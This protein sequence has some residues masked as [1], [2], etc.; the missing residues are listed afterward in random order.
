M[1]LSK[2][3]AWM[4][5]LPMMVV[6]LLVLFCP[7]CPAQSVD[8]ASVPI[9]LE[10]KIKV[11]GEAVIKTIPDIAHV[12]LGVETIGEN[13]EEVR[14]ASAEKMTA[15]IAAIK[16]SGISEAD[17]KTT[18]L[19]AYPYYSYANGMELAGYRSHNTLSVRVTDINKVSGL[20]DAAIA[21][22]TSSVM[23]VGWGLENKQTATNEAIQKAITN[24]TKKAEAIASAIGAGNVR[25]VFIKEG[26]TSCFKQS[27]YNSVF[28]MARMTLAEN[29]STPVVPGELETC[30]TVEAVFTFS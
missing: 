18:N 5:V 13:A 25:A 9:S 17:I 11:T 20:I 23:G 3:R 29:T 24:A 28:D 22:G 7:N 10:N 8:A 12:S 16:D 15:V 26:N 27:M 21:A 14:Q 19:S 30:A 2:I 6:M 1:K 4:L